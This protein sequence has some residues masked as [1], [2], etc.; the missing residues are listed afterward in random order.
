MFIE[1]LKIY[2]EKLFKKFLN[3]N[4]NKTTENVPSKQEEKEEKPVLVKI[5]KNS[6]RFPHNIY[7][8][9]V[10]EY[11]GSDYT[12]YNVKFRSLHDLY[13]Y[14]KSHPKINSEVFTKLHSVEN[15]S[16]FSGIPYSKAVEELEMPPRAGYENFLQLSKTLDENYLD[17]V[18]EYVEVKAP[19]GGYVDVASYVTGSPLC[20]KI[21]RK[22]SVP[23]FVRINVSLSYNCETTKEQ[24]MNR[25]LIVVALV[26]A[27]ERAGYVVDINMF[28]L[29]KNNNEI[30]NINV[31]IKNGQD[32]F[33]KGSLYKTLCYVEFL[34]RIL[35]RVLETI[36]VKNS[37]GNGYGQTCNEKMVRSVLKLT[38]SDIFIA[39]PDE[40]G[41]LGK[42]I[43]R[44]FEKVLEKLKLEDK[45]DVE[46]AK[47]DFNKNISTLMKTI[48]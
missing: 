32:S 45:I 37:W 16:E 12:L 43:G 21:A 10:I 9:K 28:E 6:E 18:Q 17:L 33:N 1:N 35:F 44:D 25:A 5:L 40:M 34:R 14:L 27:F 36:D 46:K 2:F 8:P 48:K 19:A 4:E 31:N 22:I 11:C 47:K 23:K 41:I 15:K 42:D 26:N 39:E 30:V 24:V 7:E 38:D 29:S 3:I 20:F 13:T